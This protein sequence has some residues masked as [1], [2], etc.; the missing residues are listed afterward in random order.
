MRELISAD[1]LRLRQYWLARTALVLLI[2]FLALQVNGKLDRL[3]EL[4]DQVET[5]IQTTEGE[6]PTPFQILDL[7]V[8]R[9]ELAQLETD[10]RYPALV[11]YVVRLSSGAGW[12]LLILVTAVV[13]GEDF[14]RQTLRPTLARGASRTHFVLAYTFSLWLA[15]GTAMALVAVLA[16]VAGPFIHYSVTDDPVTWEGLGEILLTAARAWLACLPLIAATLF[17]AV[18]GR[19]AGPAVGVGIGLRS[20]EMLTV[21]LVPPLAAALAA[22]GSGVPLFIR[23]LE[24]LIGLMVGYNAELILT[25]GTPAALSAGFV[26]ALNASG[27][28]VHLATDPWRGLV[29]CAGYTLLFAGMAVWVLRR[30]DVI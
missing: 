18:L 12:F 29:F 21:R 20:L 27:G 16:A 23:L 5:G 3:A 1:W 2:L 17:W 6:A 26:E 22:S 10:L 14:S 19:S 28:Q 9:L 4:Q 30:R 7:E 15:A 13:T 11:G 8:K 25:W 24:D